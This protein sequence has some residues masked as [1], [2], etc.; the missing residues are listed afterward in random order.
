MKL[1]TARTSCGAIIYV[2]EY[3]KVGQT[4]R[5]P[6]G[7]LFEV[8]ELLPEW[9]NDNTPE[10][11]IVR[12]ELVEAGEYI[13]WWNAWHLVT[14]NYRH[15][16]SG[17][18]KMNL[19]PED[20]EFEYRLDRCCGIYTKIGK[21]ENVRRRTKE[22]T[23]SV[24]INSAKELADDLLQ[25]LDDLSALQMAAPRLEVAPTVFV[26]KETLLNVLRSDI[27]VLNSKLHEAIKKL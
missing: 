1:R 13:W 9:V 25:K 21:T 5:A 11:E 16:A 3:C 27:K 6:S 7:Q 12:A 24:F 14:N 4:I 10:E 26:D 22:K 19:I 20:S 15:P 17:C 18:A 8:T 2:G 23:M